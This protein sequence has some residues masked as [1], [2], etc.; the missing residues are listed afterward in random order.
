M[1]SGARSRPSARRVA[2]DAPAQTAP[3]LV[4]R[5]VAGARAGAGLRLLDRG[6]LGAAVMPATA[7]RCPIAQRFAVAG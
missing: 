5:L 1:Q 7:K 2:R 4:Q 6:C 3:L